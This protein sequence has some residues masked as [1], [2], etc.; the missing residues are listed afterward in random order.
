MN[1][2]SCLETQREYYQ[3]QSDTYGQAVCERLACHIPPI[4][5]KPT[6]DFYASLRNFLGYGHLTVKFPPGWIDG[7]IADRFGLV[8]YGTDGWGISQK[9]PDERL[10][11]EFVAKVI[12]HQRA[13][14]SEKDTL[15]LVTSPFIHNLTGY[16][17]YKNLSQQL[18]ID[19]ALSMNEGYSGLFCLPTGSG[20]SLITQAL[21]YRDSGL[22]VVVVPTVSLAI[23]QVHAARNL[24]QADGSSEIFCYYGDMPG[25][26]L[27]KLYESLEAR[28]A[29]LLFLSPEAMLGS[30]A[31]DMQDAVTEGYLKNLVIDEAHM[32]LEWGASFRP[33]YQLLKANQQ[34]L[35]SIYPKL[36][37]YL[38]SATFDREETELLREMFTA[39]KKKWLEVRCDALRAEPLFNVIRCD[40]EREKDNLLQT[41]CD[42]MPRPLILYVRRPAEA[43]A[44][45]VRLRK[46]GYRH[47]RIFTGTTTGEERQEIIGDWKE[48]RLD[49]LVATSAFGMG[50]DKGDIRTVLHAYVPESPNAYYQEVG[51]GG[52]D[53]Y[54]CLGILCANLGNN[55]KND[56]TGEDGAAG[57]AGKIITE[58]YLRKRWVTMFKKARR[59][60][61][62][63]GTE[64]YG[65][66]TLRVP[67][68]AKNSYTNQ[69]HVDWNIRSLLL[70]ERQGLL[71]IE[72][73]ESLPV[74]RL[75]SVRR[76]YRVWVR[77]KDQDSCLYNLQEAE[78][79]PIRER[80]VAYHKNKY[81][82]MAKAL[83]R[84]G[85]MCWANLFTNVYDLAD[86]CCTGCDR[87]R[88]ARLFYRSE[89]LPLRQGVPASSNFVLGAELTRLLQGNREALITVPQHYWETAARLITLGC[90]GLILADD[91]KPTWQEELE[92]NLWPLLPPEAYLFII[93][94][95]EL[96]MLAD[97]TLDCRSYLVGCFLILYKHRATN[98]T[99]TIKITSQLSPRVA[100]W[101]ALHLLWEDTSDAATGLRLSEQA[102]GPLYD[103]DSLTV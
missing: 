17:H 9:Y 44:L 10:N 62:P 55:K 93:D 71:R 27:D 101:H 96:K 56:L 47:L 49:F 67:S 76:A 5:Q 61:T 77:I 102:Q 33:D 8:S 89:E 98:L 66:N 57:Y 53:G 52:R 87:H 58:E 54:Y 51:R 88:K 38:L 84:V 97:S 29:R 43:E 1:W 99:D 86:D 26:D 2:P 83:E 22:T 24:I 21:A 94:R 31:Q 34:A 73:V 3:E 6:A 91:F 70:L 85:K 18:A 15:C 23:D 48:N 16:S 50:V 39:D 60:K 30:F 46:N 68:Y 35:L 90:R 74:S 12:E 13:T 75:Q 19:A 100:G 45:A 25:D 42:L 95:K 103:E 72:R 36:R 14:A 92:K 40:S 41:L 80:E 28:R 11:A 7:D 63:D 82:Q 20:K 81:K 37:T 78:L 32:L 79:S 65:L 64:L 59:E 69:G 4:G